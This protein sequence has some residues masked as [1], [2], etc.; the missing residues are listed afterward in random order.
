MTFNNFTFLTLPAA[1]LGSIVRVQDNDF[2]EPPVFSKSPVCHIQANLHWGILFGYECHLNKSQNPELSKMK[3]S[4]S[5][6]GFGDNA[7][8]RHLFYTSGNSRNMARNICTQ[9]ASPSPLISQSPDSQSETSIRGADQSEAALT[10]VSLM[11]PHWPRSECPDLSSRGNHKCNSCVIGANTGHRSSSLDYQQFEDRLEKIFTKRH[12]TV[13]SETVTHCNGNLRS[14][15]NSKFISI[16]LEFNVS[17]LVTNLMTLSTSS[18]P[19]A[20]WSPLALRLGP[21]NGQPLIRAPKAVYSKGYGLKSLSPN[22]LIANFSRECCKQQSQDASGTTS[23]MWT[24]LVSASENLGDKYKPPNWPPSMLIPIPDSGQ[25]T[26]GLWSDEC[27]NYKVRMR[28]KVKPER[29]PR[30]N[31]TEIA[32]AMKQKYGITLRSQHLYSFVS[33]NRPDSVL[34]ILACEY[35]S[36]LMYNSCYGLPLYHYLY[37]I[38][39]E[40]YKNYTNSNKPRVTASHD[41]FCIHGIH[42]ENRHGAVTSQSKTATLQSEEI[43]VTHICDPK[44]SALAFIS[45]YLDT[46]QPLA[47]HWH[48]RGCPLWIWCGDEAV[49]DTHLTALPLSHGLYLGHAE[50]DGLRLVPGPGN[51]PLQQSFLEHKYHL[52]SEAAHWC[53]DHQQ[54]YSLSLLQNG[55]VLMAQYGQEDSKVTTSKGHLLY[56]TVM[57]TTASS[58]LF[59]LVNHLEIYLSTTV[60]RFSSE[61]VM[62]VAFSRASSLVTNDKMSTYDLLLLVYQGCNYCVLIPSFVTAIKELDMEETQCYYVNIQ[63]TSEAV[64]PERWKNALT[65]L[66]VYVTNSDNQAPGWSHPVY[67]SQVTNNQVAGMLDIS[68]HTH[69][70]MDRYTDA[71]EHSLVQPKFFIQNGRN[72]QV[73]TAH[74][75]TLKS[76]S[77]SASHL[78]ALLPTSVW[79]SCNS[80][81]SRTQEDGRQDTQKKSTVLL[82][83][84]QQQTDSFPLMFFCQNGGSSIGD[85]NV[86]LALHSSTDLA[87]VSIYA[88]TYLGPLP[89]SVTSSLKCNNQYPLNLVQATCSVSS[90]PAEFNKDQATEVLTRNMSLRVFQMCIGNVTKIKVLVLTTINVNVHSN[91]SNTP[92]VEMSAM[93]SPTTEE[94]FKTLM[95]TQVMIW[96]HNIARLRRMKIIP[97]KVKFIQE[98]SG[99][100]STIQ[101]QVQELKTKLYNNLASLKEAEN[102]KPVETEED[103]NDDEISGAQEEQSHN[104]LEPADKP[105]DEK[106]PA[107]AELQVASMKHPKED[108]DDDVLDAHS[109]GEENLQP[110]ANA[111]Q[112][113]REVGGWTKK[114]R[115]KKKL[116]SCPGPRIKLSKIMKLSKTKKPSMMMMLPRLSQKK[117][118]Q[119]VLIKSRVRNLLNSALRSYYSRTTF[120]LKNII[121]KKFQPLVRQQSSPARDLII[122]FNTAK[123][124]EDLED[125]KESF[126]QKEATH[127]ILVIITDQCYISGNQYLKRFFVYV[128]SRVKMLWSP[129]SWQISKRPPVSSQMIEDTHND[130]GDIAHL[131]VASVI[132]VSGKQVVIFHHFNRMQSLSSPGGS[133]SPCHL[134]QFTDRGCQ[135]HYMNYCCKSTMCQIHSTSNNILC[136][137]S[138]KL[139]LNGTS[140]HCKIHSKWINYSMLPSSDWHR[141]DGCLSFYTSV[142]AANRSGQ[143]VFLAGEKIMDICDPGLSSNSEPDNKQ[144][145]EIEIPAK[146][147]N[148]TK[149]EGKK[150]SE[151]KVDSKSKIPSTLTQTVKENLWVDNLKNLL[152]TSQA[153][154]P[155][156]PLLW[157]RDLTTFL[158]QKL[159]TEPS[160]SVTA[161]DTFGGDPASTL[162]ANMR[163]V[164]SMIL[165]KYSD[166]MK[167][168]FL[169]TSVANTAHELLEGLNVV[170]WN[171]LTQLLT[172]TNPSSVTAHIPRYIELR[173]SYQIRPNI[174]LST[175]WS[176]GQAGD[177][178]LQSGVKVWLEVMLPVLT[179]NHYSKFVVNYLVQLLKMHKV[180][181]ATMMNK[182]VVDLQNF[183]TIQD[184][185]YDKQTLEQYLRAGSFNAILKPIQQLAMCQQLAASACVTMCIPGRV[186][187]TGGHCR[188]M[189]AVTMQSCPSV[190]NNELHL[191][192]YGEPSLIWNHLPMP[193]DHPEME[194]SRENE[195]KFFHENFPSF[196]SKHQENKDWGKYLPLSIMKYLCYGQPNFNPQ[197]SHFLGEN[198]NMHGVFLKPRTGNPRLLLYIIQLNTLYILGWDVKFESRL[199][200]SSTYQQLVSSIASKLFKNHGKTN[201]CREFRIISSSHID[202]FR[203]K[204]LFLINKPQNGKTAFLTALSV[205][206][207]GYWRSWLD[208]KSAKQ[209]IGVRAR[210]AVMQHLSSP[211]NPVWT[212]SLSC[213]TQLSSDHHTQRCHSMQTLCYPLCSLSSEQNNYSSESIIQ[214]QENRRH[215]YNMMSRCKNGNVEKSIIGPANYRSLEMIQVTQKQILILR[216]D[217][218]GG[219]AFITTKCHSLSLGMDVNLYHYHF[220]WLMIAPPCL[221]QFRGICC[222]NSQGYTAATSLS[223]PEPTVCSASLPFLA[224]L[225]AGHLRAAS[226]LPGV[227]SSNHYHFIWRMTASAAM[228]QPFS[229][230]E[231]FA[232][233]SCSCLAQI[234]SHTCDI[235]VIGGRGLLIP[236]TQQIKDVSFMKAHPSCHFIEAQTKWNGTAFSLPLTIQPP[237]NAELDPGSPLTSNWTPGCCTPAS[238][239]PGCSPSTSSPEC[240]CDQ[241]YGPSL[242][243]DTS[244]GCSLHP[245]TVAHW[246]CLTSQ[247]NTQ[248]VLISFII[249]TLSPVTVILYQALKDLLLAL[250]ELQHQITLIDQDDVELSLHLLPQCDRP[251]VTQSVSKDVIPKGTLSPSTSGPHPPL[252]EVIIPQEMF[253]TALAGKGHSPSCL[254]ILS[255]TKASNLYSSVAHH[256]QSQFTNCCERSW[257]PGGQVAFILINWFSKSSEEVQDTICLQKCRPFG[258]LQPGPTK[259]RQTEFMHLKIHATK[260]FHHYFSM[261]FTQ[262]SSV[263]YL[264]MMEAL[265]TLMDTVSAFPLHENYIKPMKVALNTALWTMRKYVQEMAPWTFVHLNPQTYPQCTLEDIIDYIGISSGPEAAFLKSLIIITPGHQSRAHHSLQSHG[266]SARQYVSS[267][268]ESQFKKG[269]SDNLWLTRARGMSMNITIS[270]IINGIIYLLCATHLSLV[271]ILCHGWVHH[272]VANAGI[273]PSVARLNLS[274]HYCCYPH[275]PKAGK[276]LMLKQQNIISQRRLAATSSS[277]H[278]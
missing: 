85:A 204:A 9:Q 224:Q 254:R 140:Q 80:Q 153:R 250:H 116:R 265:Q 121:L 142:L 167:E 266:R 146:H 137:M 33:H 44:P 58:K 263:V 177:K 184:R 197:S 102:P 76:P 160:V 138:H 29:M 129:H 141:E 63:A 255:L 48:I 73:N 114:K 15:V 7:T 127:D 176:V 180:T 50:I 8:L 228:Q 229:S 246:Q 67:T 253:N 96:Y 166:S 97:K 171:I 52:L 242:S 221:D 42:L 131:T 87:D 240:P 90:I 186:K 149:G 28:I 45:Q 207:S 238:S 40:K 222:S 275:N 208:T 107:S 68:P 168:T 245:Q 169:E 157:L 2:P 209:C 144:P 93:M 258:K 218:I 99:D 62:V 190:N 227:N 260:I 175:L 225:S 124:K 256:H 4:E 161:L 272:L 56:M 55:S 213:P 136:A 233:L 18:S 64:D 159:I 194:P 173:N 219:S 115:V 214:R 262:H 188:A 94:L 220:N 249:Q 38:N 74:L 163:K 165:Q 264:P 172:E 89:A 109:K 257:D 120:K 244:T 10:A 217:A 261:E 211:E 6:Q 84:I 37:G 70:I 113:L 23:L 126:S 248:S 77:S 69:H 243:L 78:P 198:Q 181:E 232:S 13:D 206:P 65:V 230:P 66:T 269:M 91:L 122:L 17:L 210:A 19:Q 196:L 278:L 174:G 162:T 125:L 152:E 143:C 95:R 223:S 133:P 156:S 192:I 267:H 82:Q 239:L 43:W 201:Y 24:G 212:L 75:I 14:F 158:N 104:E 83:W 34:N 20:A 53:M 21:P 148:V 274:P 110:H 241:S 259:I 251:H 234:C 130:N 86:Y 41:N 98:T 132:L 216:S 36:S 183:L 203:S 268:Q 35:Q 154:S 26:G 117:K 202:E 155:D 71:S 151:K 31:S 88:S 195:K 145:P 182:P 205:L 273:V 111:V 139:C 22:G 81:Y 247:L 135:Q 105:N 11:R 119:M 112:D 187:Q 49:T 25:S 185:E 30:A 27:H 61:A 3:M 5:D 103:P 1:I 179:M 57:W 47:S 16:I 270:R 79:M 106:L 100:Q 60:V 39:V 164:I 92:C 226:P 215:G 271:T 199:E 32:L 134:T 72:F 101:A 193:R 59:D 200:R 128:H 236:G 54:P 235:N 147:S 150:S 231:C 252:S 178:S 170:G 51:H 191:P 276:Q 118:P 237:D 189:H 277:L 46:G 108:Q 123:C 12:K